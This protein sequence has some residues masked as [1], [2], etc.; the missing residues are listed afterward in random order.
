MKHPALPLL[1]RIIAA[2]VGGY[3][4]ANTT[5]IILSYLLP[6]PQYNAVLSGMLAS[7]LFYAFAIMW[8]F[9]AKTARKA[10]LGLLV[11]I[12]ISA[13]FLW[14]LIPQGLLE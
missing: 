1:S 11:P 5:V 14:F 7:Y 3:V 10:W 4:F 6:G 8:V 2:I 9:Y 13:A 12:I